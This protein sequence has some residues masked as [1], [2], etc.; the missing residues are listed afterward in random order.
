MMQEQMC[1]LLC[2]SCQWGH[3]NFA[4]RCRLGATASTK[5]L[6]DFELVNRKYLR[7]QQRQ[8]DNASSVKQRDVL[9]Y[10]K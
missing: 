4:E 1:S 9:F 5:E 3:P 8:H 7:L 10:I 2:I 6:V